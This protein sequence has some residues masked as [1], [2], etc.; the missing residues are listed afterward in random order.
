[1]LKLRKRT[2]EWQFIYSDTLSLSRALR[3][4][5]NHSV[6]INS[7]T[8]SSPVL[9][10]CIRTMPSSGCW[11]AAWKQ[12]T[13]LVAKQRKSGLRRQVTVGT[14][15]ARLQLNLCVLTWS[16]LDASY[17]CS[18]SSWFS[19][20]TNKNICVCLVGSER[21]RTARGLNRYLH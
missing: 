19:F 13:G 21:L 2:L 17:G 18:S 3:L 10:D 20:C 11:A 4:K 5:L 15:R 8:A 14:L 1:M 12:K 16:C 9:G 7:T 6:P